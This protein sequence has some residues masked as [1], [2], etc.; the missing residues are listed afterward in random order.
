MTIFSK[1]KLLAEDSVSWHTILKYL[2]CNKSDFPYLSKYAST[3]LNSDVQVCLGKTDSTFFIDDSHLKYYHAVAEEIDDATQN[4][5][6]RRNFS[7]TIDPAL[8]NMDLVEGLEY[9]EL[10]FQGSLSKEKAP[11]PIISKDILPALTQFNIRF[12]HIEKTVMIP[13]VSKVIGLIP[14][15]HRLASC[16]IEDLI[17]RI[18]EDAA[19]LKKIIIALGSMPIIPSGVDPN[20]IDIWKAPLFKDVEFVTDYSPSRI[21]GLYYNLSILR[22]EYLDEQYDVE[23]FFGKLQDLLGSH[24]TPSSY[25][26]VHFRSIQALK[27]KNADSSIMDFSEFKTPTLPMSAEFSDLTGICDSSDNLEDTDVLGNW[28]EEID[29]SRTTFDN[30]EKKQ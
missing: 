7:V 14:N 22:E 12:F 4:E 9:M 16:T 13:G 10:A 11:T 19:E 5:L 23:V 15:T 21:D 24:L 1:A 2:K 18:P 6:N 20:D 26:E 28:G 17:D 27:H 30:L 25:R 29:I 3:F 8:D